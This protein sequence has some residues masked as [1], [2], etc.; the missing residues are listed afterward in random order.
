M[1]AGDV[2]GG[3]GDAAGSGDL[4]AVDVGLNLIDGDEVGGDQ[5]SGMLAVGNGQA[6]GF[7]VLRLCTDSEY[8]YLNA[9]DGE[10]LTV[11]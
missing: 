8:V 5:D 4:L 1:G 7:E 2:A 11:E 10:I 9:L 3:D 6:V